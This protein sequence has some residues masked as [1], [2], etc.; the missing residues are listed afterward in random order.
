MQLVDLQPLR[1]RETSVSV[2]HQAPLI[3]TATGLADDDDDDADG[4]STATRR[5][6]GLV[7]LVVCVADLEQQPRNDRSR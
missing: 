5:V 6:I 3:P 2:V 4:K 7:A 1:R